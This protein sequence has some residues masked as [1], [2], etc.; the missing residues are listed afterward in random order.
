MKLIENIS[1]LIVNPAIEL[2]IAVAFLVF[3]YGV[4]EFVMNSGDEK[5]RDQGKQHIAWGLVGLF[6]MV[7]AFGIIK[8]ILN[9]INLG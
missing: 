4:F 5:G 8:V 6:V 9:T 7:S 2:L 1:K 3:L